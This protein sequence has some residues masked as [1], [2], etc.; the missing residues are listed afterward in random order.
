MR[1]L[2]SVSATSLV[3]GSAHDVILKDSSLN[4]E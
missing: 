3:E 1:E 2:R 4:E